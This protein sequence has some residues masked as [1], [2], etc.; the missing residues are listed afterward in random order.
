[1]LSIA[2]SHH[3]EPQAFIEECI[4]Q[5]KATLHIEPYEIIIID[6]C[7]SRP[8]ESITDTTIIRHTKNKGVGQCFD[9]AMAQAKYDNIFFLACDIRFLDNGWDTILLNEVLTYPTALT[10]T[11]VIGLNEAEPNGLN[12][13]ARQNH[14]YSGAAI[15]IF[16]DSKSNP[17]KKPNFRGLHQSKWLPY[18][19]GD[20]YEIPCILGACYGTTKQ[21]Y[22]H[23]DGFWGHMLWGHLEP[24]ISYKSYLFGGSCRVAPKAE[25]GHIF[26]AQ[27]THGTAQEALV[28]NQI[29]ISKLLFDDSQ[30]LINFLG[31]SPNVI[32]ALRLLEPKLSSILQKKQEYK[33]KTT[34]TIEE[35]IEKFNLNYR[36]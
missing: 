36:K 6:D 7:S 22:Q 24:L 4:S 5:L 18:K 15:L 35:Y 9:T 11:G 17:K 19:G 31:Y 21:W 27:G 23:V 34:L 8:L 14:K 1:M 33:Q 16:H 25:V 30:R 29:L 12:M 28:Y 13:I 32:K 26:K 2:I 10:C 3:N 20:S